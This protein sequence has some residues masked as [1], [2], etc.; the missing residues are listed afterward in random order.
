MTPLAYRFTVIGAIHCLKQPLG[1]LTNFN[2]IATEEQVE[3]VRWVLDYVY[4]RLI[5]KTV[6]KDIFSSAVMSLMFIVSSIPAILVFLL[7]LIVIMWRAI[8][9]TLSNEA[10]IG[11]EIVK[12]FDIINSIEDELSGKKFVMDGRN[13]SSAI[14]IFRLNNLYE[15]VKRLGVK[16]AHEKFNNETIGLFRMTLQMLECLLVGSEDKLRAK[17]NAAITCLLDILTDVRD[18]RG[19]EVNFYCVLIGMHSL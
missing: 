3:K 10:K 12:F 8:T 7:S 2:T 14:V 1:P 5:L 15:S 9:C 18:L 17:V 4:Q 6:L 13:I 19:N 11:Y 16:R